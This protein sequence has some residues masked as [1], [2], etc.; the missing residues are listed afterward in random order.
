MYKLPVSVIF[1][2]LLSTNALAQIKP[3]FGASLNR[4]TLDSTELR[5]T[6]EVTGVTINSS[7]EARDRGLGMGIN[8][9]AF[10]SDNSRLDFSYYSGDEKDTAIFTVSALSVSADYLLNNKGI[11]RGF[12]I[13][14]GLTSIK[15]ENISNA[16]FQAGSSSETG[17]LVRGGYQH[18]FDN[19][20]FLDIGINASLADHDYLL[21]GNGLLN[22]IN[23]NVTINVSNVYLSVGYG[24]R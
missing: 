15:L 14:A 11:H 20:L 7:A 12:F 22:N 4:F 8:A 17:L 16:E 9:G 13:G 10:L 1:P 24:F 3:Y 23:S 5:I 6:N 21:Q 18:I 19:N 2:L